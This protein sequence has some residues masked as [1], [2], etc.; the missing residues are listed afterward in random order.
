M[1]TPSF[2]SSIVKQAILLSCLTLA[3][4]PC[5]AGVLFEESFDNQSDWNVNN[6][7]TTECAGD[8]ST[9]PANWNNY[10][11]VPGT[12][13]LTNPTGSIR[14]LPSSLPDHTSGTGKAY[15]VY[16]QSVAGVNWPGDSTLVKV[17]PQDYPELYI[18]LWIRTQANW[19]TVASAQ[20]KIFRTYHW[21]RSGNIFQFFSSGTVNPA[22]IWD[23]S[24]TS[25]NA[26]SYM[27]AY[28]CDPQETNYYCTASGVP[29]YQLNDYFYSWSSGAATS[30]YA[31]AQWHRYDFHLKMNDIG[32]N[33]GVMEWWWDGQL[34]ESHSDTQWKASGSSASIGWNTI[35]IG[36]NSNN[37]F[38]STP[39]DQWYAIDDLVVS[40]TPI[41]ADYQIGGGSTGGGSS[42]A[43][44]TPPVVS[45]TSPT[46]NST[47]SGTTTL[48]ASASDNIGVSRVEYYLDG[49]LLSASNLSPYSYG[50]NSATA[51]N[52]SHT[53][54]AKAYDAAGNAGQSTSISVT[55]SNAAADTTPPTVAITS[56]ANNAVESGTSYAAVNVSDNVGVVKVEYYVNGGLDYTSTSAPFGYSV[57]TTPA[58]NGTYTMYAKAYDAAGNVGVSSTIR[59]SINNS[60]STADTSAP[61]VSI[62]APAQGA[63]VSGATTIS[64]T[65]SDNVGVSKVEFYINGA[66]AGSDSSAP[67]SLSWN[68]LAVT[69]G[70]YTLAVKAYDAAGNVSQSSAT[71]T[72][73]N[74]AVTPPSTSTA[75]SI[76]SSTDRPAVL[77]VGP[78]SPVE[79]GVRFRSDV[80]G[81]IT[82]IRFYKAAAN[83]G[84]H[85]ANLWSSRGVLLASATFSNETASG[86]QQVSFSKPVAV[87]ANTVYIASYHT[88]VGHYSATQGY[89][90]GKGTDN[91]TL[92]ALPDTRTSHN[93]VYAYG[94]GSKFPSSS[95]SSSNYW[96]DPIFSK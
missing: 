53:L 54:F 67:Y 81:Y 71:V 69:D 86:W 38:S 65:A 87:T 4:I 80:S 66:L 11:T 31:D 39:A 34:M 17:L 22:Y 32:K 6:Q 76:W 56:P 63:T 55:V 61:S 13:S 83:T 44:T 68:T 48:S 9:A 36:G 78:D 85:V 19:K 42:T 62:S 79:L 89:F 18:R 82:G 5:H 28:R 58:M 21:D 16:N 14:R 3:A 64:A 40:S 74:S 49:N 33:N 94:S 60:T 72:V 41:A 52:G 84:T 90:S 46:S 1:R 37:T 35:S 45:L 27:D 93:G 95:W 96:V 20:S 75:F 57:T 2:K 77:D 43:D 50:W 29:S 8:C 30:K 26:A 47:V 59:F 7:Y 73:K 92:H 12:S 70:S 51:A 25:A 23:W 10:R 15:I 88:M 24:T 91:A